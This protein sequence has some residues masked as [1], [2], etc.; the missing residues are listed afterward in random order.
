[1]ST[2]LQV[3]NRTLNR[4]GISDNLVTTTDDVPRADVLNDHYDAVHDEFLMSY[5]WSWARS[6]LCPA[7]LTV[8][9]LDPIPLGKSFQYDMPADMLLFRYVLPDELNI[10]V[11]EWTDGT[12]PYLLTDYSDNIEI[13]FTYDLAIT[14]WPEDAVTAFTLL[15]AMHVETEIAE[16]DRFFQRNQNTFAEAQAI[17]RQG[18]R[19][20]ENQPKLKRRPSLVDSRRGNI[21]TGASTLL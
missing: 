12:T 15:L 7:V 21:T 19:I 9:Q 16:D 10:Y 8:P 1:M 2:K 6:S 5:P 20:R 13:V 4:I 3:F 18:S 14:Q 11:E 17:A